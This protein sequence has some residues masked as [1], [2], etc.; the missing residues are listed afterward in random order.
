MGTER[1]DTDAGSRSAIPARTVGRFLP[2]QIV[3]PLDRR[4]RRGTCWWAG[5][6][7][8]LTASDLAPRWSRSWVATRRRPHPYHRRCR[9]RASWRPCPSTSCPSPCR[10]SARRDARPRGSAVRPFSAAHRRHE[11]GS[12]E[13]GRGSAP[14]SRG[15]PRGGSSQTASEERRFFGRSGRRAANSSRSPL[16]QRAVVAHGDTAQRKLATSCIAAARTRLLQ[17]DRNSGGVVAMRA[18]ISLTRC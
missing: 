2:W 13:P 17:G 11:A 15:W 7:S 9:R 8:S 5:A 6:L 3:T 16:R 18:K 12:V 1:P 14:P 4:P 10:W